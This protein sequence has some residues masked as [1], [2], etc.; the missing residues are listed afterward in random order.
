VTVKGSGGNSIGLD[1]LAR[2]Q[3][4]LDFARNQMYLKPSKSFHAAYPDAA[5]GLALMWRKGQVMVRYVSKNSPAERAGIVEGD[6]VVAVNATPASGQTLG[7]LR[8]ELM[9]E[10]GT[11]VSVSLR[12][13]E[14]A[15]VV[16][17]SLEEYLRWP[18]CETPEAVFASLKPAAKAPR[19]GAGGKGAKASRA[20]KSLENALEN[21]DKAEIDKAFEEYFRQSDAFIEQSSE[22]LERAKART[23]RIQETL[24]RSR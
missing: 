2:F 12:R 1:Y 16:K 22:S 6:I 20:F 24:D 14:Q 4:T 15:Q 13:G 5:S 19:V 8:K 10:H 7:R 11:E 18:G 21:G 23:R 3:V 17:F 9:G